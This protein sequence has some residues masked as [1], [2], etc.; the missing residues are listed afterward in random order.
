VPA[1]TEGPYRA[2]A[3]PR[4]APPGAAEDDD[5]FGLGDDSRRSRRLGWL[6]AG[7]VAIIAV[8]GAVVLTTGGEDEPET[9]D[10]ASEAGDASE[11]P[12]PGDPESP[13]AGSDPESPPAGSDPEAPAD[14]GEAAE[15]PVQVAEAF[16]AA[17]ENGDCQ[18]IIDRMTVESFSTEGQTAEEAVAEC[19]ADTEG[20]LAISEAEFVSV[21]AVSEDGDAAVVSVTQLADGEETVRDLPLERVDG[22]W[23]MDLDPTAVPPAD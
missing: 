4:P 16:F 3:P 12:A 9:A 1:A 11:S 21:E 20:L 14:G 22:V 13:P 18:G 10:P 5:P 8:A 15:S 7:V 17:V 19:E 2:T 6:L 23:K